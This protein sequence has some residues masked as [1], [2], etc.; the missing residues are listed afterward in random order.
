MILSHSSQSAKEKGYQCFKKS[1]FNELEWHNANNRY[2]N[3]N[4]MP[5]L[6][7]SCDSD[8]IT[9]WPRGRGQEKNTFAPVSVRYIRNF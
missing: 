6:S 9:L 4:L 3:A 2:S 8:R 1:S 5:R 7:S